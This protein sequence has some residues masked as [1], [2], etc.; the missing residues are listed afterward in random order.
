MREGDLVMSY[1][2]GR[3]FGASYLPK[4]NQPQ[5]VNTGNNLLNTKVYKNMMDSIIKFLKGTEEQEYIKEIGQSALYRAL[6]FANHA[7]VFYKFT[8]MSREEFDSHI[9]NIRSEIEEIIKYG[10]IKEVNKIS[11]LNGWLLEL[12]KLLDEHLLYPLDQQCQEMYLLLIRHSNKFK[13]FDTK[14]P[15]DLKVFLQEIRDSHHVAK[16]QLEA[17]SSG[18]ADI[19]V[20]DNALTTLRKVNS[21]LKSLKQELNKQLSKVRESAN[22][23]QKEFDQSYHQLLQHVEQSSILAGEEPEAFKKKWGKIRERCQVARAQIEKYLSGTDSSEERKSQA[24]EMLER[25]LTD[26]KEL[27]KNLVL[28]FDIRSHVNKVTVEIQKSYTYLF[29]HRGQSRYFAKQDVQEFK[30]NLKRIK[31]NQKCACSYIEQY[32]SGESNDEEKYF[33]SIKEINRYLDDIKE[34]ECK[35]DK[36]LLD[37]L[38]KAISQTYNKILRHIDQSPRLTNLQRQNFIDDLKELDRRREQ[39]TSAIETYLTEIDVNEE[40]KDVFRVL[41]EIKRQLDL[42]LVNEINA[43]IMHRRNRFDKYRHAMAIEED[44]QSSFKEGLERI[45]NLHREANAKL[46]PYFSGNAI[47]EEDKQVAFK[48]LEEC[49]ERANVVEIDM[50]PFLRGPVI[51]KIDQSY[52]KLVQG[53]KKS[54]I[55]TKQEM[56]DLNKDINNIKNCNID[57]KKYQENSISKSLFNEFNELSRLERR[58][59]LYLRLQVLHNRHS[60]ISHRIEKYLETTTKLDSEEKKKMRKLIEQNIVEANNKFDQ[61]KRNLKGDDT[62]MCIEYLGELSLNE[63]DRSIENLAKRASR[64]LGFDISL[65]H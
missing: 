36:F 8:E 32:L 65:H 57:V 7:D 63:Y 62:P 1:K 55:F 14:K 61:V 25:S 46:E 18:E 35:L 4:K 39:A 29:E 64:L 20:K 12:E 34:I 56:E 44:K 51:E 9:A 38:N 49:L 50:S 6:Y 19:R 16:S 27:E 54:P 60:K 52:A 47:N 10:R 23:L 28:A 45:E 58:M 21:L 26:I 11:M 17:Y 33:E 30:E 48:K 59:S 43:Q 13:Y 40:K 5:G 31:E 2:F 22:K 3:F 24:F 41:E 37:R 53:E 42:S 15:E